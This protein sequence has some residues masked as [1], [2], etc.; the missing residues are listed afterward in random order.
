MLFRSRGELF[1]PFFGGHVELTPFPYLSVFT[2]I[3]FISWSWQQI[4]DA[5]G[6]SRQSAHER[7]AS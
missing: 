1:T 3:Q 5:F 4:G 7:F 6:I 2:R